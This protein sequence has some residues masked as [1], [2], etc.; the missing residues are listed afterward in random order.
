MGSTV[1]ALLS[2]SDVVYNTLSLA[3]FVPRINPGPIF[4]IPDAATQ[5]QISTITAVHTSETKL[6]HEFNNTD[7]ALKQKLFGAIDDMFTRV[8]KN[9]YIDYANVSTKQ[10]LTHFFS[11]YGKISGNDLR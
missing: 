3:A 4:I 2:L 7:T 9:R 5:F 8:L 11:M 1:M 6:F 10:L